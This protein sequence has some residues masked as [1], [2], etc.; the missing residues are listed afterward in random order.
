MLHLNWWLIAT[1]VAN[2][3]IG[4][5]PMAAPFVLIGEGNTGWQN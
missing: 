1:I 3:S 5:H 4:N 2:R